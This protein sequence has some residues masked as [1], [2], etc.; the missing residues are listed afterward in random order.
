MKGFRE[1]AKSHA[2]GKAA[3]K[4]N[5]P[6]KPLELGR[7]VFDAEYGKEVASAAGRPGARR[8]PP[9]ARR[10]R[11]PLPDRRLLQAHGAPS[12]TAARSETTQPARGAERASRALKW[13]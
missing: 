9:P 4:V 10:R 13:I 1:G 12:R 2:D 6:S 5:E 7:T 11:S 3:S 8:G